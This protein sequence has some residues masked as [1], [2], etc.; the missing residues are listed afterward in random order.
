[1]VFVKGAMYLPATEESRITNG[2]CLKQMIS[3]N[4]PAYHQVLADVVDIF[5]IM[6]T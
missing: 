6:L 5:S 1:M 4:I 3:L 2:L